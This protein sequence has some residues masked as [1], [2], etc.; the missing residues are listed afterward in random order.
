MVKQ[1]ALDSPS[2]CRFTDFRAT[3]T[4]IPFVR[5]PKS[6]C[7]APTPQLSTKWATSTPVGKLKTTSDHNPH[8][9]ES[10]T[11]SRGSTQLWASSR[12]GKELDHISN[13]LT[14]KIAPDGMTSISHVL[15]C[16]CHLAHARPLLAIE[17]K[18]VALTSMQAFT[19]ASS[20][21]QHI[22][23]GSQLLPVV[24]GFVLHIQNLYFS[25]CYLRVWHLF[26]QSWKL[27]GP[28]MFYTPGNC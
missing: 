22:I 17:K 26:H 11:W 20:V 7:G 27:I 25:R 13:A 10:I 18:M 23:K 16:G 28:D 15:E 5:N 6:K 9:W 1:K 8:T 2:T 4:S 19:I 3:S 14:F 12:V 24:K 21:S